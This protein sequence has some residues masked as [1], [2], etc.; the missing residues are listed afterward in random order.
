MKFVKPP[1]SLFL[2][3]IFRVCF[4][5]LSAWDLK[6]EPVAAALSV[7][8][9]QVI[10]ERK[11]TFAEDSAPAS[12][13]PFSLGVLHSLIVAHFFEISNV[14]KIKSSGKGCFLPDLS[15]LLTLLPHLT[16]FLKCD[17]LELCLL[18]VP[19]VEG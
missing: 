14:V 13:L 16:S 17:R 19:Y 4:Y 2:V 11:F 9:T 10:K 6:L 8:L 18:T 1:P 5:S 12:F 3:V 7:G 15:L